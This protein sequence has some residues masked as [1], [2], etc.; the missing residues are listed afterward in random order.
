M[1]RNKKIII[2]DTVKSIED[3]AFKKSALS[4]VNLGKN[5]KSIGYEAFSETGIK[6]IFIPKSVK[7]I[8]RAALGF[9]PFIQ[10]QKLFIYG[11]KNSYAEKYAKKYDIPFNAVDL[12]SPGKTT[13][14]ASKGKIKINYKKVNKAQG[15]QVRY[16][17]GKKTTTKSFDTNK[18]VARTIN[19][20]SKGKYKVKVRA[21]RTVN[22]TKVY[23]PWTKTKSITIK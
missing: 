6:S 8:K 22:G 4:F 10:K 11:Y 13:V 1:H 16:S 12:K 5:V 19:K 15:F 20:L 23:S 2:S 18:S 21:F 3:K 17:K 7:S 9:A 14:K